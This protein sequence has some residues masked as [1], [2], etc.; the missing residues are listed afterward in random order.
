MILPQGTDI[1]G[2]KMITLRFSSVISGDNLQ[3]EVNMGRVQAIKVHPKENWV[4]LSREGINKI[5]NQTG[6]QIAM[7][8]TDPPPAKST[9]LIMQTP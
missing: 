7:L 2:L 8:V 1:F 4:S 9:N 6:Q 3:M 5:R